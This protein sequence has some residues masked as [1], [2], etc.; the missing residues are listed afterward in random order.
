[1]KKERTLKHPES[2]NTYFLKRNN[3]QIDI[4]IYSACKETME[5]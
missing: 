4:N 1:M 3:I 2:K 5:P